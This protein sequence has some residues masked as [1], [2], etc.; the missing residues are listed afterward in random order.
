MVEDITVDILTINNIINN[1]HVYIY[2]YIN[3]YI[4]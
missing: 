1:R 3:N 2:I 4:C